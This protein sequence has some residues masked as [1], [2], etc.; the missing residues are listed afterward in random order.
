MQAKCCR[1]AVLAGTVAPLRKGAT[2]RCFTQIASTFTQKSE[3]CKLKSKLVVKETSER[4]VLV[5]WWPSC[6]AELSF[7]SLQQKLVRPGFW[8]LGYCVALWKL[9]WKG[10]HLHSDGQDT[11]PLCPF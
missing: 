5:E 11:S 1:D 7:A 6:R 9:V 8:L 4:T 3:E 2:F 10:F